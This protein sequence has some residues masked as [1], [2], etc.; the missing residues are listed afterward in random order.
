MTSADASERAFADRGERYP[1]QVVHDLANL[2]AVIIGRAELLLAAPATADTSVEQ[3]ARALRDAAVEAQGLIAGLGAPTRAP[4]PTAPGLDTIIAAATAAAERRVRGRV[5]LLAGADQPLAFDS[6]ELRAVLT[7]LIEDALTA[8]EGRGDV[9]ATTWSASGRL[10]VAIE[11]SGHALSENEQQLV[12]MRTASGGASA[13][14]D[15]LVWAGGV[16]ESGGGHMRLATAPNE[17]SVV[18]I[19]LPAAASRKPP[20]SAGS[21]ALDLLLVDEQ[22]TVL[23]TLQLMLELDGRRC[24]TCENAADALAALATGR[25]QA[26][27]VD[28]SMH[29]ADGLRLAEAMHQAAPALPL[30]LTS[31]VG[32][33]VSAVERQ[34]AGAREVLTKPIELAM[35][36]AALAAISR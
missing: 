36:R 7:A 19:D 22:H 33:V 9:S 5:R 14:V 21:G 20:F 6:D 24:C 27:L 10:W 25:F 17:G 13:R 30:I 31:G 2:L 34:A 15:R 12:T 23:E 35:L 29:V 8:G 18:V 3:H 11:D 32:L 26:A 28:H 4:D 1:A 16:V